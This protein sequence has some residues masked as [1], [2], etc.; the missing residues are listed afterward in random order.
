MSLAPLA[1]SGRLPMNTT[2]TIVID[3]LLAND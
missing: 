1:G 2:G 3:I